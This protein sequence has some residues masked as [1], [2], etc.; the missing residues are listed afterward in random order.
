MSG[1]KKKNRKIIGPHLLIVFILC[2]AV[3]GLFLYIAWPEAKAENPLFEEIYKSTNRLN[4]LVSKIDNLIYEVLYQ[5]GVKEVDVIFSEVIPRH[6]DNT[7]WDFTGLSVKVPESISVNKLQLLIKQKL[8]ESSPD[9]SVESKITPDNQSIC[10]IYALDYYTHRIVLSHVKMEDEKTGLLPRVAVIIDD[11]GYDFP[12]AADFMDLKIPVTLSILPGAPYNREIIARAE[13][14]GCELL[15]HL[16]LEPKGYP[17]FN[18]GPGAVLTSMDK[19]TIYKTVRDNIR[20]VPG[21]KGVNHHMG[22]LF[23]ERFEKMNHVLDEIKRHDLFYVDSRTTNR[24]VAYDAAIT[25]GVPAAK[26]NVFIDNDLSERALR[27]QMERLLGIARYSGKAIGIGHPHRE[28][29]NILKDYSE[30]LKN[31]FDIVLVSELVN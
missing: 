25:I 1:K 5:E 19:E 20:K 23:S 11:I 22:S 18:P 10:K 15:L 21:I 3:S 24:T 29:L 16:P 17:E 4:S 12:L 30:R 31:D 6:R 27:Y 13:E 28:T 26:K 7:D 9:I 2:I 8:T 14:K